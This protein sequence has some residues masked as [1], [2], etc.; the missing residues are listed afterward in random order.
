MSGPDGFSAESELTS[1]ELAVEVALQQAGGKHFL[2][3]FGV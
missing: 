1:M 3:I 2:C